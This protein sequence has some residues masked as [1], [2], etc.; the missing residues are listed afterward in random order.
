VPLPK[1]HR[2]TDQ[3][4]DPFFRSYGARLPSSLTGFLSRA[5]VYS[6]IPPVSVLVRVPDWLARSFSWQL[7]INRSAS[8]EDFASHGLSGL[9][10]QR[11]C[12]PGPPTGLDRHFQ[13]TAGLASCVTP[14]LKTPTW[15]FR[16]IKPDVHHL[17]LS[18]LA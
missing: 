5:L 11:I 15:Q 18:A 3:Q 9:M 13:S 8:S 17:R 12:L 14:S 4:K 10:S 6:T 2:E 7:G 1:A 16:N